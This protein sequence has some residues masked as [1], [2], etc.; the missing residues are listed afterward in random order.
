[1]SDVTA[2]LLL[3]QGDMSYS[4]ILVSADIRCL[5]AR[6]TLCQT[7]SSISMLLPSENSDVDAGNN[8]L[9]L[10]SMETSMI[11]RATACEVGKW[12]TLT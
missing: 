12:P 8:N 1:M 7:K 2:N 9:Y 11:E 5:N 10:R 4:D 3:M 6:K